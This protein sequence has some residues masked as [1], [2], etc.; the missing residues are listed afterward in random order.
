MLN[1]PGTVLSREEVAKDPHPQ[2]P[3]HSGD[4][5]GMGGLQG[6]SER[7]EELLGPKCNQLGQDSWLPYKGTDPR[8]SR[9]IPGH[10]WG[11]VVETRPKPRVR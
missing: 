7:R 3:T 5:G 11:E 2:P 10:L 1:S 8:P 6:K 4:Q 9:T